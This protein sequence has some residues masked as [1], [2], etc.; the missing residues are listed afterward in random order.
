M[1]PPTPTSSCLKFTDLRTDC[2]FNV[3][4]FSFFFCSFQLIWAIV[5][6]LKTYELKFTSSRYAV[7]TGE[8][9]GINIHIS[10][11]IVQFPEFVLRNWKCHSLDICPRFSSSLWAEPSIWPLVT[12][13]PP[14]VCQSRIQ[15][16][17]FVGGCRG[18]CLSLSQSRVCDGGHPVA[19]WTGRCGFSVKGWTSELFIR[20]LMKHSNPEGGGGE[21]RGGWGEE[22]AKR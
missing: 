1:F 9:A 11:P 5:R 21:G 6:A 8:S 4:F 13:E 12:L 17:G 16:K 22:R 18:H 3:H 19:M 7:K 15:V 20:L 10:M 2:F 14:C